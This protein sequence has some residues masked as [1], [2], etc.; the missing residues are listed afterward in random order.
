MLGPH[1]LP[2]WGLQTDQC[3]CSWRRQ[4]L[5]LPGWKTRAR[6]DRKGKG[7]RVGETERWL[8]S[9]SRGTGFTG[10]P[11]EAETHGRWSQ[12]YPPLAFSSPFMWLNLLQ[13]RG[14]F[15]HKDFSGGW[16]RDGRVE[17]CKLTSS[18][19]NTKITTNCWTTIEK[20]ILEP[21][22]KDI[23]H[24][25]TRKKLQRDGRRGAIAIQSN[26]IPVRWVRHKLEII[27]SQRFSQRSESSEPHVRL[28][29]LGVWQREKEPPEHL[30]LKASGV[31]SQEFHR[32][33]ETNSTL[34]RHT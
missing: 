18:Y 6:S 12:D 8:S 29:S 5:W 17:G 19:E 3:R 14:L 34:G 2:P 1:M 25:N 7:P 20:K 21:T 11:G 16:R 31:W 28:P 9:V 33:G 13:I 30:A 26:P 10:T 32:T 23:L 27:I 22:K 4:A 15:S 24:P